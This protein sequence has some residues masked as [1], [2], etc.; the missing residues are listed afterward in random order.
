MSFILICAA[1]LAGVACERYFNLST[2]LLSAY[3][4]WQAR[5]SQP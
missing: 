2:R 5:R 3:R 1:F 4:N